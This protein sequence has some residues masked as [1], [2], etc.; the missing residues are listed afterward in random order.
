M[1]LVVVVVVVDDVVVLVFVVGAAVKFMLL[2]AHRLNPFQ[3]LCSCFAVC[4]EG[5]YSFLCFPP[6]VSLWL[7]PRLLMSFLCF[8]HL[9]FF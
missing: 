5:V 2:V 7:F 6:F 3:F 4:E 9:L 1:L 8:L